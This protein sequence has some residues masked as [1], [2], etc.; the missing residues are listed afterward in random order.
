ML[1]LLSRN[2]DYPDLFRQTPGGK[3]RWDDIEFTFDKECDPDFI[4]VFNYPGSDID[5]KCRK[6][7]KWLFIQEPP[8][9]KN[10]YLTDYFQ[11]F[12]RIYSL[13]DKKFHPGMILNQTTLPWHINKSYDELKA[14]TKG[15]I[16]NKLDRI[17]WVTSNSNMNPGHEPRLAFLE[18][19]RKS[20]VDFDL[21]GRGFTPINDKFEGV[22]PYKYSLAVENFAG[23]DYFTEKIIDV[24]LSWSMPIYFGCRNITEYFPEEAMILVDINKPEEAIERIR[25]AVANKAW[26][27]NLDAIE[28]SRNLILDKYQFFPFVSKL[29]REEIASNRGA[30]KTKCFIPKDPGSVNAGFLSKAWKKLQK[31]F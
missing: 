12:D 23:H 24:F 18:H 15:S 22:Y 19:L 11:Y 8:Y 17:S 20:G 3:A 25:E 13:F 27:R 30:E 6:G 21:F 1:V 10:N 29:I 7:G 26:E 14:L 16:Q 4:F 5:T 31:N 2:Y 9:E 28:H